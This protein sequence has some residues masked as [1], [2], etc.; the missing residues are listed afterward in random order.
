MDRLKRTVKGTNCLILGY[1]RIG[2]FLARL[3]LN[4]HASVTVAARKGK[5]SAKAELTAVSPCPLRD[6]A[7]C[8][9]RWRRTF[10]NTI[11]HLILD[12][13]L[14]PWFPS[15]VCASIWPPSPAASTCAQQS[16]WNLKP[17]GPSGF[18]ARSPWF[19]RAGHRRYGPSNSDRTGGV[20]MK[21]S[22]SAS[23][24]AALSARTK[25]AEQYLLL[26]QEYET[27]IPIVV[28]ERRFHRYPLRSAADF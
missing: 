21:R 8:L 20:F 27:V 24:S 13:T 1:G 16:S 26:T 7:G 18:P 15:R 28:R 10:Y 19:R 25:S 5:R 22:A 3:L 4:L 17:Y 9:P 12:Q 6:L 2:K 11:P 23:P 14:L